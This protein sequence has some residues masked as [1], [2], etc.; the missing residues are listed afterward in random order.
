[1]KYS[2]IQIEEEHGAGVISG[3]WVQDCIGS[4]EEATQRAT[5]TEQVNSNRI[6]VAVV[7]QVVG[8]TPILRY[9]K[10]LNQLI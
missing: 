4:L 9:F 2:L 8:T 5:K 3:S 7:E 6:K 1:M 10:E